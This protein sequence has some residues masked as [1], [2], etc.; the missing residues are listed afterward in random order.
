MYESLGE[1]ISQSL[2]SYLQLYLMK[3]SDREL[4]VQKG[5]LRPQVKMRRKSIGHFL[6]FPTS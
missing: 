5:L 1:L 4:R 6:V 3:I 2:A